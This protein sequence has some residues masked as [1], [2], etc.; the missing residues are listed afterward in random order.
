MELLEFETEV[1][2]DAEAADAAEVLGAWA[3]A[4]V[5]RAATAA[6][7]LIRSRSMS[8]GAAACDECGGFEGDGATGELICCSE[9]VAGEV[10]GD[11]GEVA[12]DGG[13]VVLLLGALKWNT[14]TPG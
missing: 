2:V 13:E 12:G 1:D 4:W 9:C 14:P 6:T 11:R 5:V 3:W 8:G 10:G 7:S